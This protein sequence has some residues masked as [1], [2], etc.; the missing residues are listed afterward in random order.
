[1]REAA[2]FHACSPKR[3]LVA[4]RDTQLLHQHRVNSCNT[5][6]I[7]HLSYEIVHR[8]VPLFKLNHAADELKHILLPRLHVHYMFNARHYQSHY[9]LLLG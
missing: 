5:Q 8:M 4:L 3:E 2:L 6:L 1:M 9:W 7:H